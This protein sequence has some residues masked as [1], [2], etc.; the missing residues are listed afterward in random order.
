MLYGGTK[1]YLEPVDGTAVDERR[2]HSHSASERI[3]D[4]TH[5]QHH[6]KVGSNALNEEVV[7]CQRSS[8]DFAALRDQIKEQ[9]MDVCKLKLPTWNS[10]LLYEKTMKY[11]ETRQEMTNVIL[12]KGIVVS[13]GAAAFL[14][15]LWFSLKLLLNDRGL[16]AVFSLQM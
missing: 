10:G 8:V 1:T 3:T 14:L 9:V 5:S 4:G 11:D 2:K 7:H 15:P 16:N 13:L 12:E 6:M